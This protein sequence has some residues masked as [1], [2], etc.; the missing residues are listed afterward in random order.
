MYAFMQPFGI[1]P[2]NFRCTIEFYSMERSI[3]DITY[4]FRTKDVNETYEDLVS[5]KRCMVIDKRRLERFTVHGTL[6]MFVE[7]RPIFEFKESLIRKRNHKEG[8]IQ[9]QKFKIDVETVKC[10]SLGDEIIKCPML[11]IP[12]HKCRWSGKATILVQHLLAEHSRFLIRAPEFHCR[13]IMNRELLIV[14]NDEVFLYYK[15]VSHAYVYAVVQQ[16]GLTGEK[17]EYTVEFRAEE[18]KDDN[19][20]FTLNPHSIDLPLETIFDDFDCMAIDFDRLLPF[21]TNMEVDMA[22]GWVLNMKVRITRVDTQ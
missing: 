9:K 7:V 4:C 10:P 14:F 12:F 2:M 6:L 5:E 18:D 16:V 13:H 19:I 22:M 1:S 17:Y 21:K 11:R 20:I 15:F 3:G 8:K